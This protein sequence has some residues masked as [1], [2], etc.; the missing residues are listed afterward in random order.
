MMPIVLVMLVA[1]ALAGAGAL[2]A[3]ETAAPRPE[4]VARN[5][6]QNVLGEGTVRWVRVLHS[7]RE[8]DIGWDA[9]LYRAHE[10]HET[11]RRQLRSEAE[12]ATGSIMGVMRPE[13]IRFTMLVGQRRI[14]YG[15]HRRHGTFTITYDKTLEGRP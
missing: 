14:A 6:A 3:Q 7:G 11:N 9:V 8:I 5:L 12:L 1:L 4:A 10:T 13:I 2:A 15:Q